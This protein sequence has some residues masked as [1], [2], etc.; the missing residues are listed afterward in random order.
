MLLPQIIYWSSPVTRYLRR[1]IRHRLV[2]QSPNNWHSHKFK[3]TT[4]PMAE[5]VRR[6]H[7]YAL[8][9]TYSYISRKKLPTK[10]KRVMYSICRL[11]QPFINSISKFSEWIFQ[12]FFR[13]CKLIESGQ[14]SVHNFKL[15]W[16]DL[17]WMVG[18]SYNFYEIDSIFTPLS[19]KYQN[20]YK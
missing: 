17:I 3:F 4:Y 20:I 19:E 6:T 8:I 10:A 9:C 11:C 16:N 14:K 5:N 2:F 13:Q 1:S 12:T 7:T 15:H 18:I